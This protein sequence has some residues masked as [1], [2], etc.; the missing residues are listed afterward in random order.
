MLFIHKTSCI[1]ESLTLTGKLSPFYTG[2]DK[3][4]VF[5]T[6]IYIYY[7][8]NMAKGEYDVVINDYTRAKLL[9]KDTDVEVF[10]EV[11]M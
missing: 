10:K 11:S 3:S 6:I 9:Y 2:K 1:S 7:R 8:A 5:I 4:C